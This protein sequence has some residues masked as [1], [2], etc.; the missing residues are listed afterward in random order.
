M[1]RQI[2]Q[3]NRIREPRNKPSHIW[4]I[5]FSRGAKNIQGEKNGLFSKGTGNN[6][7]SYAKKKT[8]KLV[9]YLTPYTKLKTN[10]RPNVRAKIIQLLKE[11]LVMMGEKSKLKKTIS[12]K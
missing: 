9:P 12:R 4:S 11:I 7:Y 3:W 10:Q 8:P 1:N 6:G 2:G 5:I